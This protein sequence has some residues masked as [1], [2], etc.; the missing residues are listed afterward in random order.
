MGFEI[1]KHD[2]LGEK[3]Y[4][5]KHKS[6]LMIMVCPKAGFHSSYAVIGTLFGSINREFIHNGKRIRVPDGTAHY[7]EH[8]LFE[9][10]EGDAFKQYAKT[11]ASANAYTSFDK[12]CYLFSCSEKFEE[13]LEILFDLIQSPYFTPET[14]AKEQGIIGQ[15]IKMYDDNPEWCVNINLMKAMYQ[16]HPI[17]TDIAG[18]V[19]SIAE[20][21]PEILYECYNS[22]YNLNNMVLSVAGDVDPETVLA[23]ADRKLK[24]NGDVKTESVFPEEPYEVGE[25]YIEQILPVSVPL[26]ALGFK[27]D[28]SKGFATNK[29]LLCTCI[30]Q[31]AF[32]GEGSALYRELL[33]KKLINSSFYTEYG[34]GIGYRFFTFQGETKYPHEVSEAIKQAVSR[35]HETGI[36]QDD[37]ENARRSIYGRIVRGFDRTSSIAADL[38]NSV[39]TGR[40]IYESFD[41]VSSVTLEDVNQRLTEQLDP[42]NCCLSVI[43]AITDV[44]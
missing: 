32:A 35:L 17:N 22:Y 34:E 14:V 5:M 4:T 43:K 12:T 15:E 44:T 37:F 6:G 30:I 8:K 24:I 3:Y 31:E 19:E 13:S 20:I 42:D 33:D 16:N 26:F 21:T 7:L 40:N 23:A 18:T 28:G 27:E 1:I 38:I 39:F 29:E 11:G 25:S 10:E 36:S 2:A 41:L 9:S